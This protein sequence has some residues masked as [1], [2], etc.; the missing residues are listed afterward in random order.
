M[1]NNNNINQMQNPE[2]IT[3]DA[4]EVILETFNCSKDDI[5]DVFLLDKGMTNSSFVFT[6]NGTKY[7]MRIPGRGTQ[8][9]ISRRQEE[10]VYKAISGYKFCNDPVY[11]NSDNGFK[12][13][14]F[15]ENVRPCDPHSAD[16]LKRCM[17]ILRRFHSLHLEVPHTF[18]VFKKIEFY[19]GLRGDVPSSY[20]EFAETKKH[21]FS[22]KKYINSCDKQFCLCHIDSVPDN[23]LFYNDGS[24]EEKLQLTDWEYAGMQ[25]PHIDIAMFC[26][27]SIYNKEQ[28]D[29][30][31][32]IYFE[33]KCDYKTRTKIY[34][35][36]AICGFLW[37]NWCEYKRILGVEFGDYS[38]NQYA[39]ATDFYKLAKERME[40]ED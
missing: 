11:I 8:A 27:Y 13:T 22:L 37:S 15:L 1:A 18:D 38:V 28:C 20:P 17:D 24:K 32:D 21:I 2:V 33:G 39:Y 23:F 31:I 6:V 14:E 4:V 34:C 26:V 29:N 5:K 40:Q 35:Y 25:D 30:L 19:E 7:I 9:L 16:D 12:I 3:D 10:Q 36:I